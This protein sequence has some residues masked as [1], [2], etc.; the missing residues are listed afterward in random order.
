VQRVSEIVKEVATKLPNPIVVDVGAGTVSLS[1][2]V[3]HPTPSLSDSDSDFLQGYLSTVLS[4]QYHLPV[5]AIEA[6]ENCSKG[7]NDRTNLITE[8]APLSLYFYT[9]FTDICCG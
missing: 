6:S 9:F 7:A 5:V 2:S 1:L 3:L 4:H 8:R